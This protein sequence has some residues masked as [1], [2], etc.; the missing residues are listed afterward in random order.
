MTKA[1]NGSISR[2]D[3]IQVAALTATAAGAVA[4][5]PKAQ[6]QS[7]SPAA[8]ARIL[9]GGGAPGGIFHTVET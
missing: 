3:M 7:A 5:A 1:N 2:R 6:A 4:A 8:P 9:G